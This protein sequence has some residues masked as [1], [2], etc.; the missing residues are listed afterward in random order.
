MFYK[1]IFYQDSREAASDSRA[2]ALHG[3]SRQALSHGLAWQALGPGPGPTADTTE[4][5][6]R[7]GRLDEKCHLP[8]LAH[9]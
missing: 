5:E 1:F 9:T 2:P 6:G 7:V 4:K 3:L 8:R